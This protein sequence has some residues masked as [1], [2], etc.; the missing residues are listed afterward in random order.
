MGNT[1][2]FRVAPC[3]PDSSQPLDP[4]P[5]S[6]PA[7]PPSS[8]FEPEPAPLCSELHLRLHVHLGFPMRCTAPAPARP[9]CS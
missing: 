2:L 6:T 3:F 9:G 1:H 7:L 8:D 5:I 4:A